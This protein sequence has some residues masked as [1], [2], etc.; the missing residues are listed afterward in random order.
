MILQP[1]EIGTPNP[2]QD[3][4]PN[5]NSNY[6]SVLR[7]DS[8]TSS[9]NNNMSVQGA[10]EPVAPPDE[11]MNTHSGPDAVDHHVSANQ[12]SMEYTGTQYSEGE[13][14]PNAISSI[15]GVSSGSNSSPRGRSYISR[16]LFD[17]FTHRSPPPLESLYVTTNDGSTKRYTLWECIK[18]HLHGIHT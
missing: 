6:Y 10:G 17:A 11:E 2:M 9:I 8:S 13:F 3:H 16:S 4:C 15:S 12:V 1:T 7:S 18:S 14:L 5:H